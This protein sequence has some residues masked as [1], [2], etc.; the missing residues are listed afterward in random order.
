[1]TLNC[2][3]LSY[4]L[5]VTL[6][7]C[8]FSL[9]QFG[10]RH[11]SATLYR[12][13]YEKQARLRQISI[14]NERIVLLSFPRMEYLVKIRTSLLDC[15]WVLGR[16]LIFWQTSLCIGMLKNAF[17][18]QAVKTILFVGSCL[19]SKLNSYYFVFFYFILF[20]SF[21]QT[22]PYMLVRCI[23]HA[24]GLYLELYNKTRLL[25]FSCDG[26]SKKCLNGL[27]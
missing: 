11:R 10:G 15:C 2:L 6:I 22:V 25:I 23:R 17:A 27:N 24:T 21:W 19:S 7:H 13:E 9:L 16:L 14:D 5:F 4:C 3:Q 18:E 26:C 12:I 1:M 20:S 8:L